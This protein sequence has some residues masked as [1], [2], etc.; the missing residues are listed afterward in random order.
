MTNLELAK[1]LAGIAKAQAA[2]LRGIE[3]GIQQQLAHPNEPVMGVANPRIHMAVVQTVAAQYGAGPG[4]QRREITLETLP[5]ELL[6]TALGPTGRPG[7]PT[8]ER[9]ALDMLN[10]LLEAPR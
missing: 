6:N 10:R 2:L 3:M 5:S 8:I 9:H 7:Q 4:Q 1:L